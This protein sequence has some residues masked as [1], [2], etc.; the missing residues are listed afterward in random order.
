MKLFEKIKKLLNLFTE[1]KKIIN[2][3]EDLKFQNGC[4]FLENSLLKHS[5]TF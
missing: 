3:I 5:K 4:L 1:N 2:E